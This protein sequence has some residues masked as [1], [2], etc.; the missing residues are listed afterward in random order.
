MSANPIPAGYHTV[1]VQLAVSPADKAIEFYKAAFGA[2]V[3]DHALDPS[4][5][6][7]WHASLRV[8]T[9]MVFVNDVFPEMGDPE[10]SKS[11]MWLYVADCDAVFT[12]AVAAGA[13]V[14][15]PVMDMFW[16]DRTGQVS[17]PFGQKWTIATRLKDMTPEEIREAEK[18][19]LAAMAQRKG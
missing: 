15:M 8:G 1:V 11:T 5:T 2:E 19:F 16:G 17:D 13:T 6:K 12:Q 18:A 14:T 7:I 3:V 4:G 10:P 9:S